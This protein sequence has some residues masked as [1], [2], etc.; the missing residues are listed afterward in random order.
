MHLANAQDMLTEKFT[1]PRKEDNEDDFNWFE[2]KKLLL[3]KKKNAK[4]SHQMEFVEVFNIHEALLGELQK[5]YC[6]AIVTKIY[7]PS[8]KEK[9]GSTYSNLCRYS[10]KTLQMV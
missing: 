9:D 7:L 4:E 8:W 6:T 10:W 5:S 3:D 2:V 1:V